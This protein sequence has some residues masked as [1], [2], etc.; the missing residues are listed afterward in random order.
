MCCGVTC[1]GR[2]PHIIQNTLSVVD[3]R[4]PFHRCHLV[5]LE[6]LATQMIQSPTHHTKLPRIIQNLH[7]LYDT[8][9]LLLMLGLLFIFVSHRIYKAPHI[10]HNTHTID[11]APCRSLMLGLLLFLFESR[12]SFTFARDDSAR[13]RVRRL[14]MFSQYTHPTPN[15]H[16]PPPN[17]ATKKK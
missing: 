12:P 3:V 17:V 6:G 5:G 2:H 8:R 15:P 11:N 16:P 14:N 13:R 9:Y 4:P 7:T 10:I 1:E